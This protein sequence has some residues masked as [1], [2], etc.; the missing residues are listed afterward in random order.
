MHDLWQQ[1]D[2][3][4]R[5]ENALKAWNLGHP[6]R[7]IWPLTAWNDFKWRLKTS[8]NI[9]LENSPVRTVHFRAHKIRK[10]DNAVTIINITKIGNYCI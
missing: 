3:D 8:S 5:L 6:L 1:D 9:S 7:Q 2:T 4:H 10:I